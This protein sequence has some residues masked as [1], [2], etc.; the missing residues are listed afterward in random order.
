MSE[1]L[2]DIVNKLGKARDMIA[3][4][5]SP[6]GDVFTEPKLK[7]NVSKNYF[8]LM[9]EVDKMILSVQR[10]PSSLSY[11]AKEIVDEIKEWRMLSD[12]IP[13]TSYK[14]KGI[15]KD[16]LRDLQERLSNVIVY[17]PESYF[18]TYFSL[19]TLGAKQ[20]FTSQFGKSFITN[21]Q[22]FETWFGD[23]VLKNEENKP[24]LF[25][26]GA[27]ANEFVRFDFNVFPGM[28]FAENIKYAEYFATEQGTMY[29]VYLRV[30]NPIDL[31]LFGV[32]KI[33]YEEFV[34]YVELKYGFQ[35]EENKMLKALSNSQGGAWAWQYLRMS[36]NWLKQVRDSKVFDGFRFQENNPDHK[37]SGKQALTDAVMVF[38]AEQIKL[39]NLNIT[40]SSSSKDIR[41]EKGGVM[42]SF[43]DLANE[44]FDM[45]YDQ[46]GEGEKEWVR[47]ERDIRLNK[48]GSVDDYSDYSCENPTCRKEYSGEY[49]SG[50]C[51][52][53]C[54]EQDN[55]AVGGEVKPGAGVNVL[56][57]RATIIDEYG[58][59]YLVQ[60]ENGRTK[61]A[62]KDDIS[63]LED[64]KNGGQI[65]ECYIE[66][67]NK[68]KGFKKD[69]KRFANYDK[70]LSWGKKNLGNFNSD[71]IQYTYK[72]GGEVKGKVLDWIRENLN[73][74]YDDVQ[75]LR[76]TIYNENAN[77]KSEKKAIQE[78]LDSSYNSQNVTVSDIKRWADR[79]NSDERGWI[80][81]EKLKTAIWPTE[82]E[83]TQV[84][85]F[86]CGGCVNEGFVRKLISTELLTKSLRTNLG[87]LA[88]VKTKDTNKVEVE[89]NSPIN[90]KKV[91][92][93]LKRP[94]MSFEDKYDTSL[95]L[96]DFKKY[97]FVIKTNKDVK[98]KQE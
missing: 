28:Y 33:A 58:F 88:K 26:H 44:E 22:A 67:L 61:V 13:E 6:Y 52:D 95:Q 87:S 38:Y 7:Q 8:D 65:T 57:E 40:F 21:T 53:T 82:N 20:N 91:K 75:S 79:I 85:K 11:E 54:Y 32:D 25:F 43:D 94:I 30:S 76:F 24:I 31:R 93:L 49:N 10:D 37:I 59:D 56:G 98:M 23:S 51:S 71:M 66:Y 69:K 89:F 15:T 73:Y 70:A 78:A 64:Y 80:N 48:G 83:L 96:T 27:K 92:S 41:F 55:Y 19:N 84:T 90:N 18:N 5:E 47:D 34:G 39:A 14:E 29:E 16:K 81:I 50:Y 9:G 3:M 68:D 45:D 17:S 4:L 86:N 42:Y 1:N 12:T 72:K 63:I 74:A 46:L 2:K 36:P 60:L 62:K 77:Y 35:L 97:S